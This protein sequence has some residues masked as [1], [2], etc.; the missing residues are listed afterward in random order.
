MGL[1]AL[2]WDNLVKIAHEARVRYVRLT[3]AA[4]GKD[5][6]GNAA[7][8]MADRLFCQLVNED[9]FDKYVHCIRFSV[10]NGGGGHCAIVIGGKKPDI[11]DTF[12][13]GI[14]MDPTI[15]QFARLFPDMDT[16]KVVFRDDY[17]LPFRD[18]FM[19]YDLY[20]PLKVAQI[21]MA[22]RGYRMLNIHNITA[23]LA[24]P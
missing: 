19:V 12:R 4:P 22:A 24:H 10:S 16:S 6:C 11:K 1:E 15:I 20:F 7:V 8:Y 14:K 2:Q 13:F 17:P 18:D 23:A 5:K 21:K 3:D 9:Y